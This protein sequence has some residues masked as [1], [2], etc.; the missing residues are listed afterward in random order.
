MVR[1]KIAPDIEFN[2]EINLEGITSDSSDHD[3]QKHKKEVYDAF[4]ARL[5]KAFADSEIRVKTFEFGLDRSK[6]LETVV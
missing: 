1:V 4:V 5:K 2:M 6:I 3:V